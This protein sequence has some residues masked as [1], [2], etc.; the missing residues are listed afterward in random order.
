MLLRVGV[1]LFG[2]AAVRYTSNPTIQA[3]CVKLNVET[4]SCKH[5]CSGKAKTFHI[6]SVTL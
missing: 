1:S 3:M 5:F 4:R 6:L 2:T